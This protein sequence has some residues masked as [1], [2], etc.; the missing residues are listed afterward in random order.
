M[1][2]FIFAE[3]VDLGRAI[4]VHIGQELYGDESRSILVAS[5]IV[6]EKKDRLLRHP[7]TMSLSM[8]QAQQLMDQLWTCGIRP[9]EGSGS[10]GS[11]AATQ[12]HLKDMQRITFGL[13][14]SKGVE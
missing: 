6:M 12:Q 9:S 14:K 4:E 10:A 13:L 7:P 3:R 2:S 8:D 11:L 5:P 1:K